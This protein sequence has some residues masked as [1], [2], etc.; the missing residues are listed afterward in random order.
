M[1]GKTGVGTRRKKTKQIIVFITPKI[2]KLRVPTQSSTQSGPG[3]GLRAQICSRT[4]WSS[5]KSATP[6]GHSHL[7]GNSKFDSSQKVMKVINGASPPIPDPPPFQTRLDELP[8]VLDEDYS[9]YGYRNP[10]TPVWGSLAYEIQ[11][12]PPQSPPTG[13]QKLCNGGGW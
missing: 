13:D 5:R 9:G 8:I 2:R 4:R 12:D 10:P 6:R 11:S 1:H 3:F 7:S